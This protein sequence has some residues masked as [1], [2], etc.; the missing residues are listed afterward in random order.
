MGMIPFGL[1]AF[2]QE[3]HIPPAEGPSPEDHRFL[4]MNGAAKRALDV[5]ITVPALIFLL[6]VFIIVALLIWLEDGG[7]VFFVQRRI[8]RSGKTFPMLKFRSM[9]P[10]AS[11]ALEKLLAECAHSKMEWL[12]FQKLRNDPR[13][14]RIG[15]FLRSTSI[16]ELPQ[17][18]NVFAGHMSLVGQRPILPEQRDAYGVHIRGYER[19]RPG[20]TGL[21]QISGRNTLNFESRAILGSEYVNTWSLLNDVRIIL[22]TVPAI[23]FSRDAF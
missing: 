22:L 19:M 16:D 15:R 11:A 23:L 9:R 20:I 4:G 13:I 10:N 7:P 5:V 3:H 17:L 2:G 6:P 1:R 21:W 18:L 14:T 12:E 8:G